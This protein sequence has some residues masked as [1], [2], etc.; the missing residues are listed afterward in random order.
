MMARIYRIAELRACPIETT[1]RIV[2][3]RWTVLILREMFFGVTQFNR[4]QENVKGITPKIL[5]RR[6]KELQRLRIVERRIVSQAPIR[7]E[8]R[9]TDIG[10]RLDSVLVS[11]AAFSMAC[12]PRA[13]F[14]DGR[15]RELAGLV[16]G[17]RVP[18]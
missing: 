18:R 17:G 15:S 11:A 10:R 13:V 8:Y 2:G 3:K 9:L 1:F 4:L 14:K 12:L 6:L 16:G 7:I 5:S